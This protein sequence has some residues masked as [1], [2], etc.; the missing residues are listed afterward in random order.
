MGKIKNHIHDWLESYGYELGYDMGNAPDIPD[1]WW[2]A[3]D[4]V[5]AS[6]YWENKKKEIKYCRHFYH[7]NHLKNQLNA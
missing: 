1:L 6:I 3:E 4:K 7:I 2:V 5:D